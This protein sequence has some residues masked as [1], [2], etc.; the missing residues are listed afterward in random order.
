MKKIAFAVAALAALA[1]CT[2]TEGAKR[3]AENSGL[4]EVEAGGYSLFGCGQ[5]DMFR[6]KFTAKNAVGKRVEGVVCS[7]WFK[8]ST[9]RFD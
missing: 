1:A 4:T 8:G 6:T 9:V 7:S 2:D 3:A 5:D